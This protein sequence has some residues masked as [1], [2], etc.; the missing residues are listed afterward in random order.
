M[1][2][3][4]IRGATLEDSEAIYQLNC[5]EMGY[6]YD[7]EKTRQ[8]MQILLADTS[9]CIL[10]A[11]SEGEIVGYIHANSHDLIYSDSLKN[12]M[13]IAVKK[14]FKQQGIGT[15]LLGAIE[16]WAKNCGCAGVRLVSGSTRTKAHQFYMTC[17]YENKKEQ[18]NFI[19]KF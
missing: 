17:G 13:G 15:K 4:L 8:R 19:K 2:D 7:L 5:D 6:T 10:V 14:Q 1:G 12:I 11:I 9:H 16:S 3:I 18:L